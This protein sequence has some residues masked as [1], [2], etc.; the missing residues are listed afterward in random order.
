MLKVSYL[1]PMKTLSFLLLILSIALPGLV[2]HLVIGVTSP[3]R[4]TTR[5]SAEATFAATQS[6]V[7]SSVRK[8]SLTANDL[9]ADRNSPRIYASVPASVPVTGNSITPIDTV[10]ATIGQPVLIGSDPGK[11]ALT[12]NGQFLYVVLTIRLPTLASL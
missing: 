6:G 4:I 12:D 9:I 11:M 3:A 8:I 1:I 7:E 10:T 2:G 5:R